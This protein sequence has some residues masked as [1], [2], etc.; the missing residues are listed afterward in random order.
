MGRFTAAGNSD[1]IEGSFGVAKLLSLQ[2]PSDLRRGKKKGGGE[3]RGAF[4]AANL[5]K[6]T[7]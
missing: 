6:L 3:E 1:K 2:D 4:F 5:S 7:C